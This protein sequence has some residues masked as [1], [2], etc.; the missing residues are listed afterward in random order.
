MN[1][2]EVLDYLSQEF[3]S[4]KW[5]YEVGL[6]DF[7]R[8]T[9]YAHYI[10]KEVLSA[11]PD[12]IGTFS[13]NVHFASYKTAKAD[14]YVEKIGFPKTVTAPTFTAAEFIADG[15]KAAANGVDVGF[16]QAFDDPEVSQAMLISELE[17][18]EKVCGSNILQDIFYETHDGPNAVTNLS[19]RYPGVREDMQRLYVM[20][21]FD[22]I[23]EELDG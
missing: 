10:N 11:V 17:R 6:D 16:G 13:V 21:G 14:Q 23:Y 12:A 2:N 20:Y 3:K 5:F 15:R 18:L 7:N 9:V 4:Q 22:V 8:P 19:A 1:V